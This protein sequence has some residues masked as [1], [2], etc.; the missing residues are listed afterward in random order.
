MCNTHPRYADA[1]AHRGHIACVERSA[2]KRP[3]EE[4]GGAA[5]PAASGAP[6]TASGPPPAAAASAFARPE[7][8]GPVETAQL[9][10]YQD[11]TGQEQGPH[12]AA[13]MRQWHVAGYFTGGV[14]VA[15][16]YYG[17]VPFAFWPIS[18]LWQDPKTEAFVLADGVGQ[19]ECA[20]Q[21]QEEFVPC[22]FFSGSREGYV[23]KSDEFGVGYYLDNPPPVEVNAQLLEAQKE[24]IKQKALRLNSAQ[25]M[26]GEG[27]S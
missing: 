25:H 1:G 13:G 19:V 16:S 21:H 6:A 2:M 22:S 4:E 8:A 11:S 20:V 23:F 18:E 3:H 15:A 24:I 27:P 17:E 10:Y 26:K 9:W 14:N 7:D 5:A 12:P